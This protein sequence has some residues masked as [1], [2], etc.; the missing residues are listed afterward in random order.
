MGSPS[1][2]NIGV[3]GLLANQA[4]LRTVG[5]NI[6]NADSPG[7]SR[8]SVVQGTTTPQFSGA[9]FA[10]TGVEVQSIR[11]VVD[12][13]AV[14]QLRLDSSVYHE[15]QTFTDNVDQI[16]SL[17]ADTTT[18]LAPGIQ[19]FFASLNAAA[20]DPTSV[21]IRQLVVSEAEG[22]VQRFSTIQSRLEQHNSTL[23][24]QLD[25]TASEIT[26]LARG[27]AELNKNIV[28]ASGRG[29]GSEPND[30]LDRRDELLRQ[31]SELVSV[32]VV[33]KERNAVDVFIGSG[34]GLV[35]GNRA[36]QLKA[37]PG[38]TDPFR[39]DLAFTSGDVQQTVTPL[40]SGGRL[41]GILD[42][43]DQI[44]DETINSVG[45]LALTIADKVNEQHALGLDLDGLF[46]GLFFGDINSPENQLGRVLPD[47]DN[48]SGNETR[49]SVT[50]DDTNQ[51]TESDYVLS[52]PG[53][54][55]QRYV[56]TRSE[57]GEVIQKGLLSGALPDSIEAEGFTINV[58]TGAI[59]EGDR[60]LVAPTRYGGRDIAVEIERPERLAVASAISA[61]ASLG[62]NG[63]AKILST[64]AVD[65]TTPAFST[66]GELAPPLVIVFTSAETYDVLDNTNPAKPVDLVPPLRNLRFTPGIQNQMLPD[67]V[68]QTA[69]RSDGEL[70]GRLPNSASLAPIETSTNGYANETLTV[71]TVNPA[72]GIVSV[73]PAVEVTEGESAASIAQSLNGLTGVTAKA[74]TEVKLS[75]FVNGSDDALP[76]VI[77]INGVQVNQP[78]DPNE[79][80]LLSPN[81][82]AD[83]ITAN[84]DF[85]EAG[86]IARSNGET[87][88][89]SNASGEDITVSVRGD[90][91]DGFLMTDQ[92]GG[93]L[94]I[95]GAGG[96]IPAEVT[97]T[98]D[99]STGFNFND[100]GPY[101][102][103]LSVNGSEPQE[104]FLSGNRV[105]SSDV[106]REVQS[107]IDSSSIP[108]G[109]I[110]VSMNLQGQLSLTTRER[111]ADAQIQIVDVSPALNQA[112]GFVPGQA[113]GADVRNEVTI[114]G[115]LDVVMEEG[116]SLSSSA[117]QVTGNLFKG[118]PEAF[119]TYL[120]YQ[121]T[122]DG[123]ADA[124]DK[125]V[126]EFNADGVS[127]NR[128]GLA[129]TAIETARILEG[130]TV[131][132]QESYGRLV[133]LVGAKTAQSQINAEA[134]K[135]LLEQSQLL[136]DNI[137]GVSL[138]EEA[139][140]LIK[141]ELAYNASAQVISVARSLF[142]TL[143][144][145][146]R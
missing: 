139:A 142:D 32:N 105:L 16:D 113:Q 26:S 87:L 120:G 81:Y 1:L 46:G 21:P 28:A 116:V 31:L 57:D 24:Q 45:R 130:N 124:G 108:G 49:L 13:F 61:Q 36:S 48:N 109:D 77:S 64:Q 128:N 69:V 38:E 35:V 39:N 86:I 88:T 90:S 62:N 94:N 20:D 47:K 19:S 98:A 2:L 84:S 136:R 78:T 76:M 101:R 6:S 132:M 25:T 68:G 107:K 104:I 71:T 73:Q 99:I 3:S 123:I 117:A 74:A 41:G 17:L 103:S 30:L 55:G 143:I 85:A 33:D 121:V 63:S 8:Q 54:G 66:P 12:E 72:T 34:Q 133:E 23:N 114:G 22:L 51:L 60:F 9:G 126:V 112:L 138:D 83:L 56:L 134:S 95:N 125:F 96:S 52:F 42:F 115:V 53:P 97:G 70:A 111:G 135:A 11:R 119:S 50:I 79:P 106:I 18:G 59:Q 140:D 100:G 118:E 102:F 91:G 37:V 89:L 75:N 82:L 7:Y 58:E 92:F 146:F 131:N 93:E 127:D 145:T 122:M 129:L 27:I 14:G 5:H 15:L 65:V 137:A 43:R 141:Y 4:A 144:Q 44:L 29:Q 10:G 110:R 67:S 80:E 40:I